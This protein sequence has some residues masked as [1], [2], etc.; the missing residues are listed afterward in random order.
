MKSCVVF[1]N[2]EYWGL[3]EI[4]EKLSD[5]FIESNYGIE[6]QDVAMIKNG[7]LEEG[8]Q[9]ELDSFMNFADT[10]SKMDLTNETN[11]KAVCDY[12]N[13]DSL[14]E[15]YAAGLYLGTFDW[16]NYN[17]GIWRNTGAEMDA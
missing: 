17:Y 11:Y 5:Y 2:G 13:I 1:L 9:T 14:I 6:K 3:Y 12:I 15:H 16:P 10:Y 8:E 7:E 4:T